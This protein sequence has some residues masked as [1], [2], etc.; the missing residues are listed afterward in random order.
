MRLQSQLQK[1]TKRKAMMST[2]HYKRVTWKLIYVHNN[3]FKK[4]YAKTLS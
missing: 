2:I 3:Q 4:K 1:T